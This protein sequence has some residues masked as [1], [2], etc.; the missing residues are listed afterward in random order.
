YKKY[1]N[2]GKPT[3]EM[4]WRKMLPD[5]K[6]W[7]SAREAMDEA[8]KHCGLFNQICPARA[9]EHALLG[10]MLFAAWI[11]ITSGNPVL[12]E[13]GYEKLM[14]A[15]RYVD[16]NTMRLSYAFAAEAALYSYLAEK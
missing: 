7:H 6:P 11:V 8:G 4:D 16:W 12:R 15:I 5:R 10:N 9:I 2:Q 13:R 1:D 14:A 3:Y